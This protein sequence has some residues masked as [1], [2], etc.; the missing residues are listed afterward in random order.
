MEEFNEVFLAISFDDDSRRG[1][2]TTNLIGLFPLSFLLSSD[3]SAIGFLCSIHNDPAYPIVNSKMLNQINYIYI[4][5]A[6]I[7]L[8]VYFT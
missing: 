6:P 1:V 2:H 4:G 8:E 3:R 7:D 5:T